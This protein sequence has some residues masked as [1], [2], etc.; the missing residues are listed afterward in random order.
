MSVYFSDTSVDCNELKNSEACEM[1]KANESYSMRG[2]IAYPNCTVECD[3][4][5][6][7]ESC[8]SNSRSKSHYSL[9]TGI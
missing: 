7:S 6:E 9:K 8:F 2:G 3:D 1:L 4:M 5:F